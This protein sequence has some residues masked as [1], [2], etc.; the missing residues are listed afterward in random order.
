MENLASIVLHM[1]LNEGRSVKTVD[2]HG[3][4]MHLIF[5][6]LIRMCGVQPRGPKAPSAATT[7]YSAAP[8]R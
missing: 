7:H 5:L 8:R 4:G 3:L 6:L 1:E 2:L